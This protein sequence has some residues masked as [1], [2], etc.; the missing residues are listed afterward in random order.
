MAVCGMSVVDFMLSAMMLSSRA[1]PGH[2]RPDQRAEGSR[3]CATFSDN[4]ALLQIHQTVVVKASQAEDD[5]AMDSEVVAVDKGGKGW[6]LA[7]KKETCHETCATHGL[8][9][10]RCALDLRWTSQKLPKVA[11]MAQLAASLGA[12]AFGR[13]PWSQTNRSP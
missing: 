10:H 8:C 7:T 2:A 4:M 12:G 6:Y 3:V 13:C 5:R 9:R 1:A 11:I